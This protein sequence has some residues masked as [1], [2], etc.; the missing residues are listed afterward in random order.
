[1]MLVAYAK[2]LSRETGKK[3]RLPTEAEWEYAARG[4]SG[5]NNRTK[6]QLGQFHRQKQSQ[7][8]Q[9]SVV[10]NGNTHLRLA[11]FPPLPTVSA[12]M[13]C[14]AMFGNGFK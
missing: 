14:T 5:G 7:L 13:T 1:M 6:Y 10:I 8:W 9:A 11:V 3:Y 2:W 12:C 4:D